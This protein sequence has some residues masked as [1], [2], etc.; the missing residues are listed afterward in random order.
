[1]R[2]RRGLAHLIAARPEA[3]V[4]PLAMEYPF[5]TEARPEALARF[6][7][8]V[9][10]ADRTRP[11]ACH[12][13]LESAL[14]ATLD[15]LAADSVERRAAAFETLVTDRGG[16]GGIWGAIEAARARLT[17]RPRQYEHMPENGP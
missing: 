16:V 7:P 10:P 5:W 1:V 13:A 9:E 14:G 8:P 3:T 6:G 15:A 11:E 12:E 4:V 2:L 17:G